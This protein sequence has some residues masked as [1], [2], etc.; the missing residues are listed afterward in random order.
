MNEKTLF[1]FFF[2]FILISF[3]YGTSSFYR[4]FECFDS[5]QYDDVTFKLISL[6]LASL[7][8]ALFWNYYVSNYV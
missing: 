3:H 1:L 5:L 6:S 7:I 8:C 4:Q 2:I